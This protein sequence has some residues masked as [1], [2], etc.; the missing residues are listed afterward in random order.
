M[1]AAVGKEREIADF[2][3]LWPYLTIE[4]GAIIKQ[5]AVMFVN[6]DGTILDVQYVD[7]ESYPV[8]PTTRAENP[9]DIPTKAGTV[10]TKYE[11][12]GW[13]TEFSPVWSNQ[14]IKAVYNAITK[15]YTV[16][17]IS[18]G[19]VLQTTEAEYGTM[20]LYEGDSLPSN[21]DGESARQYHL[22]TGW[23]KSGYVNGDK[24]IYAQF[25]SCSYE[26]GYFDEKDLSDLRLVELYMMTKLSAAGVINGVAD[27][28]SP[29]D[30]IT[31]SLGHDIS[32]PNEIEEK[33][34]ISEPMTFTGSNHY[35]TGI[36]L[37]EQDRD[38]VLAID[39]AMDSGN[40]KDAV[41]AQC[42]SSLDTSGFKLSYLSGVRLTWGSSYMTPSTAPYREMLI[43]RHSKGDNALHIYASNVTGD[44]IQTTTLQG[45]HP[46]IHDVS[47]VFGCN[48]MDDGAYEHHAK[49]TVYWSKVWYADLG[50]DICSRL[51][52][53]PHETM[54]FEACF[55]TNGQPK[56]YYISEGK[57]SRSS[58]TFIAS[59]LMTRSM[60]MNSQSVSGGSWGTYKLKSYLDSRFYGAF[61]D[62]WKQLIKQVDV[63]AATNGTSTANTTITKSHCYIFVPSIA[64]LVAFNAPWGGADYEGTQI[65]HFSTQNSR[66]CQTSD[67]VAR[68]YWTRSPYL[69]YSS[70]YM[71]YIYDSGSYGNVSM[72]SSSPYVRPMFS[73]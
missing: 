15:K 16:K 9:I 24:N 67:G 49:G 27:Y 71:Y 14:I 10:S 42:F 65:S 59:T 4:P 29:K 66:I 56:R 11:F 58:I 54:K 3:D 33:V 73:I 51:A 40:D 48:K 53:W 60:P 37:L 5:F 23:D 34:L 7:A 21:T 63:K 32:Y 64:E 19:T 35:D 1:W 39:Y 45:I 44:T 8:D 72:N 55:E 50:D 69:S 20:V 43:I 2:K 13:D 6:D 36:K 52:S 17:Y 12:A 25:D 41:L 61:N 31:M 47:L 18:N 38:F 28:I 26:E 68:Y 57:G 46:M 62:Q 22:F 70:H 30:Q